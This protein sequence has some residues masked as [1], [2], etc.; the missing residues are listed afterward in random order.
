MC[1]YVHIYTYFYICIY[2]YTHIYIYNYIY[3]YTH[4]YIEASLSF[5]TKYVWTC[6]DVSSSA[7][8]AKYL[9]MVLMC[10][11][12]K[13]TYMYKCIYIYRS[14]LVFLRQMWNMCV[15]K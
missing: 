14:E 8:C 15:P 4:I 6:L 12:P 1:V 7:S 10:T 9:W 11:C 5:C 13:F 3:E 2:M